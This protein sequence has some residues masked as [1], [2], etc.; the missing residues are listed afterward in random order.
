MKHLKEL[1]LQRKLTQ[2]DIADYLKISRSAYTNYE[3]DRREPDKDILLKLS[4]FFDV[5]IDYLMDSTRAESKL[6]F[7]VDNFSKA[8]FAGV[9]ITEPTK[10]QLEK[11]HLEESLNDNAEIAAKFDNDNEPVSA[12]IIKI[13]DNF[14]NK[15]S[16]SNDG[17]AP[18]EQAI[19]SIY[20]MI[21]KERR[22]DFIRQLINLIPEEQSSELAAYVLEA[23][24][25]SK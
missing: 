1:R 9:D 5:S 15:K 6:D 21:P 4:E 22:M 17:L 2:Q 23:I 18:D 19:I 8:L 11:I 7:S 25:T 14:G 20:K 24:K 16:P 12:K 3:T 13:S 10:D